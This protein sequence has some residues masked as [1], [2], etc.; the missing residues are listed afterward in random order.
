MSLR[1]FKGKAI[2]APGVQ[3]KSI[4]IHTGMSSREVCA[5]RTIPKPHRKPPH[6]LSSFWSHPTPLHPSCCLIQ[7]IQRALNKF[8]VDEHA[9]NFSLCYS[10]IKEGNSK[11]LLFSRR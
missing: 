6:P 2:T 7:V 9:A 11:K 3:Y 5:Q 4:F 1:I 10:R 8:D